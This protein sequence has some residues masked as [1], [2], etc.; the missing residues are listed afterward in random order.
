MIKTKTFLFCILLPK[1]RVSTFN[2]Q[3]VVLLAK[4]VS[5]SRHQTFKMPANKYK[6]LCGFEPR[7]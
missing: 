2:F 7:S 1:L 3:D 4:I 6:K 5:R